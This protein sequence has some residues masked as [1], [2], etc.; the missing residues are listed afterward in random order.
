MIKQQIYYLINPEWMKKFKQNYNYQKMFNILSSI[1]ENNKI[2]YVNL[3]QFI[4]QMVINCINNNININVLNFDLKKL[5]EDFKDIKLI[6]SLT[7]KNHKIE[8]FD[9][10]YILPIEIMSFFINLG[11]IKL[12]KFK[13][14]ILNKNND[15]FLFIYSLF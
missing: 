14:E 6:Y 11:L 2:N 9:N 3:N 12:D 4:N 15:M 13:K 5:S 8:Y 1:N 10:C 7:R